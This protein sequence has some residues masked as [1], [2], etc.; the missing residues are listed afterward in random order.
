MLNIYGKEAVR[1]YV[2][3]TAVIQAGSELEPNANNPA[4]CRSE[5]WRNFA[6]RS[7]CF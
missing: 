7:G 3:V 1:F 5:V 6:E 2:L 4:A